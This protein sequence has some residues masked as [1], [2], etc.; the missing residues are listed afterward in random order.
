VLQPLCGESMSEVKTCSI[1]GAGLGSV[2]RI[3][4]FLKKIGVN[5]IIGSV[6]QI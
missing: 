6:I 1:D 4:C 3:R 5:E 2:L